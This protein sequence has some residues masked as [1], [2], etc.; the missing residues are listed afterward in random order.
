MGEDNWGAAACANCTVGTATVGTGE[1][2]TPTPE[3][4]GDGFR[5]HEIYMPV[6]ST[7]FLNIQSPGYSDYGNLYNT[8][9]PNNNCLTT[10]STDHEVATISATRDKSTYYT[11]FKAEIT[12]GNKPGIAI[13]SAK[14]DCRV[15]KNGFIYYQN[16]GFNNL[17]DDFIVHVY[18][19]ETVTIMPGKT[20]DFKYPEVPMTDFSESLLRTV[21]YVDDTD[22]FEITRKNPSTPSDTVPTGQMTF[23]V[24]ANKENKSAMAGAE[25]VFA[26]DIRVAPGGDTQWSNS[27]TVYVYQVNLKSEKNGKTQR[28]KNGPRDVQ[29]KLISDM[30]GFLAG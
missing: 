4:E 28:W 8:L 24:K 1:S 10:S 7:T 6:G 13:V 11:T 25:A 14:Y 19:P 18:D 3:P 9:I 12:A 26:K 2:I 30:A 21:P 16:L 22:V 23:T 5:Q 15:Q 20:H 27:Y 17:V 29:D